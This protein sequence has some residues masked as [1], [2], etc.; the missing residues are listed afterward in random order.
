MHFFM[1]FLGNLWGIAGGQTS[2]GANSET[3]D[4]NLKECYNT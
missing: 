3:V 4:A 1:K 2:G